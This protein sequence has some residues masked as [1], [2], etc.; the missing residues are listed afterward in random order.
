MVGGGWGM[1][2]L[3]SKGRTRSWAWDSSSPL[4]LKSF[5]PHPPPIFLTGST[6][7]LTCPCKVNKIPNLTLGENTNL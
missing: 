2:W 1:R 6:P 5:P 3:D 4:F 7:L